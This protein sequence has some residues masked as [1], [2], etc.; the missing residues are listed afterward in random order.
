MVRRCWDGRL[1]RRA[2]GRSGVK[3]RG[4]LGRLGIETVR[5]LAPRDHEGV[6]GESRPG[7]RAVAG[8][9]Y[10]GQD[11]SPGGPAAPYVPGPA[12]GR[13]RSTFQAGLDDWE[14]ADAEVVRLAERVNS[15][16]AGGGGPRRCGWWSSPVARLLTSESFAVRCRGQGRPGDA[17]SG[18]AE[19]AALEAVND[20]DRSGCCGGRA[21]I[22]DGGD[23]RA[24]PG[25]GFHPCRACQV[26]I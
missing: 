14:K 13:E 1:T 16:V 22:G 15:H 3:T 4:R 11:H 12:A 8:R 6:A 26:R 2:V 18:R 17:N 19:L 23:S 25:F 24:A 7:D 10:R 9:W 21:E 5:D 20:G